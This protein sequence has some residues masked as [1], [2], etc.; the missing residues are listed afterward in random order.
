MES[1]IKML[2]SQFLQRKDMQSALQGELPVRG[3]AWD[4][5][6][7]L[8]VAL[9][10]CAAGV[11]A[12][13]LGEIYHIRPTWF[14]FAWNSIFLVPLVA[15]EFHG[16]FKRPS[17]IAFFMAWMCAHG[18]TVVVMMRWAPVGLWPLL[19]LMELAAG[20]IAAHWLFRFPLDRKQ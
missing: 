9:F 10:V 5:L 20:F 4:R 13:V 7:L 15:R 16:Y 19:M 3:K 14:F 17:F 1:E 2:P 6:L 12:V 8:G 11:G 18:A